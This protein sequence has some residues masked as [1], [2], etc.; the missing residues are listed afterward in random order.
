M[1]ITQSA[2]A[3]KSE[4][5]EQTLELFASYYG[6]EAGNLALKMLAVGGLYLGG[7]IAPKIIRKLQ[8]GTFLK[9][10]IG[11]GRMKDLLSTIPVRVI[12]NDQ[13]ALLGAARYA[14]IQSGKIL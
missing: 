7:G 12:M 2:L 4:L 9:A 1:A 8:E 13:T 6:Y 5:C 11:G 14:A 10:F 3:G